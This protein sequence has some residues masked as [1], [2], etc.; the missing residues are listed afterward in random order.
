MQ[1]ARTQLDVRALLGAGGTDTADSPVLPSGSQIPW[2][3]SFG[4]LGTAPG[5]SGRGKTEQMI[6]FQ[7]QLLLWFDKS[8][9]RTMQTQKLLSAET[10]MIKTSTREGVLE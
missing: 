9:G 5:S 4:A 1:R 8:K 6:L 10:G 2:G 7:Q 3:S